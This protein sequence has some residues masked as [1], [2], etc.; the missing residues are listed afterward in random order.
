M[1]RNVIY[2]KSA[3]GAEAIATRQHG[4]GPRQRSLLILVDGKRGPDE[5]AKLAGM[6]GDAEQQIER[7]AA[8][9]FIEPGAVA[10]PTQAAASAAARLQP[11]Q[12][13]GGGLTLVAAQ[14]FAVRKLTDLLGPTAEEICLRIEGTRNVAEFNAAIARA[15]GMLRQFAGTGTAA[16]F[17]AELSTFRPTA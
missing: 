3:K 4:L 5:L 6:L 12:S 17:A 9:G 16:N 1:N 15:E 10:A 13:P 2:Q 8:D 7:L 11:A 14:R